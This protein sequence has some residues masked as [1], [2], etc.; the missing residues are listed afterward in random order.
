MSDSKGDMKKMETAQQSQV[1]PDRI[2]QL[3]FRYAPPLIIQAGLANGVFD[4]LEPGPSSVDQVSAATGA[5]HRGLRAIMNA[6]VGLGLWAVGG[7]PVRSSAFR[8]SGPSNS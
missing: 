1:T 5:S 6:I 3:V 4:A 8:R 7:G 2:L